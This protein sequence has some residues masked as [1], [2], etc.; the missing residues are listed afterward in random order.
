MIEINDYTI[1]IST[2]IVITG[3][4]I[5]SWLNRRHEMSKKDWIID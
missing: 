2:T 4:F 1:I 3:W 5:N